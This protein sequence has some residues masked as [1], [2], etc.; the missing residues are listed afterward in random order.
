MSDKNAPMTTY[1]V[2]HARY[3]RKLAYEGRFDEAFDSLSRAF[4]LTEDGDSEA[5]AFIDREYAAVRSIEWYSR[6]A[7]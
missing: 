1:Y 5:V 7:A 6:S 3:A 4:D 2:D